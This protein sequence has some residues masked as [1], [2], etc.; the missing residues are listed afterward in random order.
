MYKTIGF[1]AH[2]DAGKTTLSEQILYQCGSIRAIGRVDHGDTLLDHDAIERRRGITIYTDQAS[3]RIGDNVYYLLDTPGHVDFS[4]EME[5]ALRVL[6]YAVLVVSCVEGVQAH[7]ELIWKLLKEYDVPVFFFLNKTDRDGADRLRTLQQI[8]EKCSTDAVLLDDGVESAAESIA[9][10][11]ET[12]LDAYF[13]T[14]YDPILWTETLI[15]LIRS[16]RC[17]PCYSGSALTGEGV[18]RFLRGFDALTQTAYA[19]EA[20][21]SV[22]AYKVRHDDAGNRLTCLKIRSGILHAKDVLQN[23]KVHEIRAYAGAH[24]DSVSAVHAGQLCTVTGL[25]IPAGT[26]IGSDEHIPPVQSVPL[27]SAAVRFDPAESLQKVL[28]VFRLLEEEDPQM[29]VRWASGVRQIQIAVMGP[30]QLEVLSEQCAQRFGL[31]VSFDK[32]EILYLETIDAPVYGCGHYEPL[33]HY[34]EV[35]ILLRPLPRGSGIR[36]SSACP[37][38]VLKLNWQRLIE[39]HVFEKEHLGGLCGFPLTDV[40]VVLLMGRAHEK[41]TEGGDF[42]QALY[43]AV[44]HAV[45]HAQSVLIEPMLRFSV[46]VPSACVGRVLSDLERMYAVYDA[47]CT[48]GEE[49]CV[50]GRC[51]A[52]EMMN[53]QAELSSFSKGRGLLRVQFDGYDR[54]HDAEAVV[55]AHPYEREADFENTADSFFCSHGAGY[56]VH[57]SI[58]AEKMHCPIDKEILQLNH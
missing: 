15:S 32:P 3:F 6:D 24:Y 40:E 49:V 21:L 19:A 50:T 11:D 20:P 41:H 53:Y 57:W 37:T 51:P 46:H 44:R 55:Q 25:H 45:F 47:P 36:F 29:R 10:L 18:E 17:F 7:T 34:A 23:E 2:V 42:R 39:T 56:N 35:H 22:V 9:E 30:I 26:I 38:D 27:M 48:L 1:L 33:R 13:S 4:A 16:R 14:G 12:L 54:C 8:R 31:Q 52:S 28:S 58:A 5:R 43:R